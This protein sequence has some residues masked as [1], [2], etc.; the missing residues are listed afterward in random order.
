[1]DVFAIHFLRFE[2]G[3]NQPRTEGWSFFGPKKDWQFPWP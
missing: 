1:M 2:K 3:V